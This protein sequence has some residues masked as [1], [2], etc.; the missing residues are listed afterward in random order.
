MTSYWPFAPPDSDHENWDRFSD[1]VATG[2]LDPDGIPPARLP[3]R[4]Y[5]QRHTSENHPESSAAS[6]SAARN[7]GDAPGFTRPAA[8]NSWGSRVSSVSPGSA[9]C[10]LAGSRS[11][12]FGD[13][14]L[15]E[16]FWVK[17][18]IDDDGCWTWLSTKTGQ[19]Y[20]QFRDPE[21][22]GV[23]KRVHRYVY[24]RVVGPIPEG[25]VIDHLCRNRRCV[26]PAHL[27]AVTQ[28]ENN[29]RG[30]KARGGKNRRRKAP[31]ATPTHGMP[32]GGP[33]SPPLGAV[34]FSETE[35]HP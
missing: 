6:T 12:V 2:E 19:G 32:S 14:C 28:L 27:E 23:K 20:G 8:L 15:P 33:L 30:V 17:A 34:P 13:A 21:A 11:V 22:G 9:P 35:E 7:G 1:A 4:N 16:R 10:A 26:N 24:E 31:E 25:L 5:F 29:H 18:R 3:G